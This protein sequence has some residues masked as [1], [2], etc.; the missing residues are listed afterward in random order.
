M[1]DIRYVCLSYH[2]GAESSLL[3]A[4]GSDR[5]VGVDRSAN[6]HARAEKGLQL[7]LEGPAR[8]QILREAPDGSGAAGVDLAHAASAASRRS[9]TGGTLLVRS[10]AVPGPGA[11]AS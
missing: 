11:Q 8:S 6:P 3:S 4:L 5:S 2:F 1:P 7:S 10:G 9:V